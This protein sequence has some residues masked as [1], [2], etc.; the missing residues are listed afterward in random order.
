MKRRTWCALL[1]AGSTL[2]PGLA[3]AQ[4]R[5]TLASG[6]LPELFHT[7]NLMQFAK[8]VQERTKGQLVIEVKPNNTAAKLSEIGAQVRSGQLAAGEVLLSSLAG[9]TKI[10]GADAIPFIVNSYDDAQRL[11]KAQRPVL[12]DALDR[13]GLVALYAVPWPSQGL[14]TT[15][16]IRNVNDMRGTKMRSY[17]PSTVR[18]AQLMG[19][20]PVD[21]PTGGINQAF[22]DRKI[23]AMFTSP[24]TGAESRVW[25]LPIKY[26]YNVRGWYPK[27]LVLVNKAQW[28]ALSPATR[29]A[30]EDAAAA[31]EARGW[32]ASEAASTSATNELARNGIKVETPDYELRK[33]LRRLGEQFSLEYIRETGAEGNR[34]MIPY[35]AGAS[36][37]DKAK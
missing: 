18:I 12:Q 8:E 27:N 19:A 23:E 11:W 33:D 3:G 36:A 34:M 13:Q 24:V 35:F 29:K 37:N 17:N 6:Y 10:A 31:A 4:T 9:E 14:F 32:T 7:V 5:W 20:T 1:I 22:N 21:V 28:Q 30:V 26:F 15:R 25:D 16:A 2:L